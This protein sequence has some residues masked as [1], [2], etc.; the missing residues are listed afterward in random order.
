MGFGVPATLFFL[1]STP[2]APT[3]TRLS[4]MG[5][6]GRFKPGMPSPASS[7]TD[8]EKKPQLLEI[9]MKQIFRPRI[10]A[11]AIVVSMGGFIFGKYNPGTTSDSS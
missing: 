5:L 10:I 4:T 3:P 2:S 6:L 11:M 7:T 9:G 1:Q 8:P